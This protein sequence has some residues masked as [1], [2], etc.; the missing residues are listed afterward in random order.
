MQ[1]YSSLAECTTESI[2]WG[3]GHILELSSYRPKG[4]T[5]DE[6]HA[7]LSSAPFRL[8]KVV[9]MSE[10]DIPPADKKTCDANDWLIQT[11]KRFNA[12]EYYFGGTSARTYM[13]FPRFE[14]EGIALVE[15]DWQCRPYFQQHGDF[16]PNLSII[17]LLMNVPIAEARE[18]LHSKAAHTG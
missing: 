16:V 7:A 15:Q 2:L 3:L 8:K 11:C 5:F 18:I 4:P 6:I 13:D 12:G 9:R 10:T 1:R 14:N 17:D